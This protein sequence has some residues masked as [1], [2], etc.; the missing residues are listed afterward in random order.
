MK[1][2]SLMRRGDLCP[3]VVDEI[4]LPSEGSSP[5]PLVRISGRAGR[6]LLNIEKLML[7]AEGGRKV[8]ESDIVPYTDPAL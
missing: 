4:P 2:I 1:P 6:F 8:C 7:D 5:V 3:T